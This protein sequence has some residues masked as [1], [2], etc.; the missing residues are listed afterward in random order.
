MKRD[1]PEDHDE[2]WRAI[3]ANY[4][5]PV[6]QPDDTTSAEDPAPAGPDRPEDDDV[7]DPADDAEESFV[8]PSPPPVPKPPPDRMIAWFGLFGAPAI[9]LAVVV[10][11]VDLPRPVGWLLV[12]WFIAGFLYLVSRMPASPRDPWD[13]GAQV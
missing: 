8:P 3:V 4:G 9:L 2:A 11:G 5:E 6:L 7:P 12:A 13:D 1:E 10:T